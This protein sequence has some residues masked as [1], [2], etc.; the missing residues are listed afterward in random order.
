MFDSPQYRKFHDPFWESSAIGPFPLSPLSPLSPTWI[1][2]TMVNQ[3]PQLL[4][5]HYLTI[6]G[7][8]AWVWWWRWWLVS[9]HVSLKMKVK[10]KQNFSSALVRY[11]TSPHYLTSRHLTS[12]HITSSHLAANHMTSRTTSQHITSH[13]HWHTTEIQPD[14]TKT[15]TPD[16]TPEGSCTQKFRSGIAGFFLAYTFFPW[17]FHPSSPGNYLYICLSHKLQVFWC[18]R[19]SL[20]TVRKITLPWTSSKLRRVGKTSYIFT[21]YYQGLLR[22]TK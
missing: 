1:R 15:P 2:I 16:G 19:L 4:L 13:H 18:N 10:K 22:T 5:L 3:D 8:Q 20:Q 7:N 12:N 17:N 21:K 14:T 9:I 11:L 6:P